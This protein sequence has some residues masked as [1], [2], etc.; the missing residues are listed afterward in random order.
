[1]ILLLETRKGG[2]PTI[3][4]P[5]VQNELMKVYAVIRSRDFIATP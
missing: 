3:S 5:A 4:L 2:V 1:M